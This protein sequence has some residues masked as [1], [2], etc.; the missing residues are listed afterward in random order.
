M[1]S[2][3][4]RQVLALLSA[5]SLGAGS[6]RAQTAPAP[7]PE[8]KAH[9]ASAT[10][11]D[12]EAITLDPFTVSTQ[13]E[14]YKSDDT[15]AGGRVRTLLRDT[16][17]SLSVVTKKLMSDL[18]VNRQEDLFIYTTNTEVSGLYGNY[19]GM[20]ARGQGIPSG[21]AEGTRLTNPGG[22]NRGRGLTSMDSTRNYFASDIPWDGYNIS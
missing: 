7:T 20:T 3:F 14:G 1:N 12:E 21:G 13:Q 9:G 11:L 19:S 22:V 10:S 8:T 6:V 4:N 17:S 18:N 16:P 15:L 2:K 5:L